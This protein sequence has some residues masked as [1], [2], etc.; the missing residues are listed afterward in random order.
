MNTKEV[1][2]K[3]LLIILIMVII[4]YIIF[5]IYKNIIFILIAII[6]Y[7]IL[8]IQKYKIEVKALNSAITLL[9]VS[10]SQN[11]KVFKKVTIIKNLNLINNDNSIEMK[12]NICVVCNIYCKKKCEQCKAAYYCCLEHQRQNWSSHKHICKKLY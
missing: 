3:V 5:L 8:V 11:K 9:N 12:K 10:D 4:Q 2:Y 1:F 6:I 7:I